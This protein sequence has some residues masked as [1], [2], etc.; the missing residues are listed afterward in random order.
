SNEEN[1]EMDILGY[2]DPNWSICDNCLCV[3]DGFC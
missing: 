2:F 1:I 3:C